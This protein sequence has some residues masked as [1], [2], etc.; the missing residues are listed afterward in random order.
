MDAET[1]PL[2]RHL[3]A[4]LHIALEQ[5]FGR[6]CKL[7]ATLAYDFYL[8]TNTTSTRN[9]L[10]TL[11]TTATSRVGRGSPSRHSW[12]SSSARQLEG[13]PR[14][15]MFKT[16]IT[17]NSKTA[18]AATTSRVAIWELKG[19]GKRE[20]TKEEKEEADNAAKNVTLTDYRHNPDDIEYLDLKDKSLGILE[21]LSADPVDEDED[22]P[23][24]SMG[25]PFAAEYHETALTVAKIQRYQLSFNNIWSGYPEDPEDEMG[26][27]YE[28]QTR[29]AAEP[30]IL[31]ISELLGTGDYKGLGRMAQI[32]EDYENNFP[33]MRGEE[34]R[35]KLFVMVACES[36]WEMGY[37]R[38]HLRK[39]SLRQLAD[40]LRAIRSLRF[41]RPARNG[42]RLRNVKVDS[43]LIK[44]KMEEGKL[45]KSAWTR[46]FKDLGLHEIEEGES[47]KNA[48]EKN[49]ISWY[50]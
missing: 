6:M 11:N 41:Q 50:W 8:N 48:T 28:L 17:N 19:E 43:E 12:V 36:L 47:G 45:E 5:V 37:E 2:D 16:T 4:Y 25:K 13:V 9:T 46:I 29:C 42:K 49:V 20:H 14:R 34:A 22:Y 27:A 33:R 26:E 15:A 35:A 1:D 38:S 18:G 44:R 32:L 21:S 7:D 23:F 39:A 31:D 30:L 3:S 10:H 40:D 24:Y